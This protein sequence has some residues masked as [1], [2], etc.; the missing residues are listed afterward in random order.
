[1]TYES[2]RCNSSKEYLGYC[3]Q[4]GFVY[5]IRIDAGKYAVVSLRNARITVLISY[6]VPSSLVNA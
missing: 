4:K 5:S 1:M 3:E 2:F 6:A